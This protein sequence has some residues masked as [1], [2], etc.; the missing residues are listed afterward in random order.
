MELEEF[1]KQTLLSISKGVDAAKAV[2]CGVAARPQGAGIM[3]REGNSDPITMVEFDIA[4]TTTST[5]GSDAKS[6]ITVMGMFNLGGD[7]NAEQTNSRVSRIKF[8]VP[9]AL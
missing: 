3:K 8:D 4:V 2:N 6:G 1:I 7:L 5:T 9:V